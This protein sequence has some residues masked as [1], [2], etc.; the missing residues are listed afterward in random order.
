MSV[1]KS[2]LEAKTR[3]GSGKGVA[4][5][6]RAQGLVPAVV[7]GKHLAN[8]VH[9]AVD[10]KSV[11]AAINTPHKFNTLISVKLGGDTHQVLLKDYQMDPVTREILHV[12]FIGVR[13]NEPVKVNVPLVLTGKAVGVADGGLLT[14]V[15]RELEVWALPNA[16][17]EK[18]EAD[19]SAMKIAEAM[20]VNDVKLPSGVSIKTNVNYTIA[21]ISAP[22]AAEA[23]PAAAAAAA[24]PAAGAAP[25]AADAKAGGDKAAAPAAAAKPAAKK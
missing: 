20:H 24:A 19:V 10:P 4:R 9:V 14:Q 16:I 13:E 5:R 21:V 18:I 7:Y 12:D 8:P 6:L 1:D 11:R 3:E 25:K 15:R 22:E 2:T 23:A 17:P